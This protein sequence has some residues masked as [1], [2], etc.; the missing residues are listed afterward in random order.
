MRN[1]G[2]VR[3]NVV[4]QIRAE[5]EIRDLSPNSQDIISVARDLVP[6]IS[7]I[8]LVDLIAQLNSE[9]FGLGPLNELLQIP[10]ITDVVVHGHSDIWIDRG[11]GMERMP[12]PWS[13]EEQ[14]RTF[15]IQLAVANARRLDE[16]NPFV[17]IQLP[18]GIRCHIIAPPLSTS[19]TQISLRIPH[20]MRPTLNELLRDQDPTV[21]ELMKSLIAT[22]KSM[23][24]CGGTGTGKTTLLA[25]ILRESVPSERIVVIEDATEL[26][27]DHPHVVMLQG[28]LP[29]S[30]GIGEI[31]LRTLVR[32][33]LRMRPDKIVV[34]EIRGAEVLE[35]FAALNTGHRGCAAT[36]HA[37]GAADVITRVQ[38]LGAMNGL[39]DE[40]IHLQLA[41]A[42]D[43]IVEL[44]RIGARRVIS[45]IG[46]LKFF[47]GRCH[48]ESLI[49]TIPHLVKHPEY[50]RFLQFNGLAECG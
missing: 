24:I 48:Y 47:E 49:T 39:S 8:E 21:V 31:P 38:L 45:E 17:D 27:I 6:W 26:S 5:I 33:A 42:I 30:E 35:F 41:S 13:N 9:H 22:K 29:N 28:R 7:D 12:S 19:G 43:V 40:A 32:Q 37:N 18:T 46:T 3:P 44:R 25:A 16:L 14:V 36:I 50:F 20:A 11:L 23:M 2:F 34:G 15:A 1:T 10:D 4:E